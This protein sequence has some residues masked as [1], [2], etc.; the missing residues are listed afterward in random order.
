MRR[1][2]LTLIEVMV[3][4]TIFTIVIVAVYGAFYMGVRTWQRSH[5]GACLQKV[6]LCFLRMEKEL[7]KSLFFSRS[8]FKGTPSGIEFPVVISDEE[9]EKI[10]VITYSIDE[11]GKC[12]TRKEKPFPEEIGQVAEERDLTPLMEEIR[13][14][15]AYKS[16]DPSE[17]LEWQGAWDGNVLERLPSGV[18]ISLKRDDSEDF[19]KKV[20][21]L[22]NK[23]LE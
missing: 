18:R 22:Q 16:A 19:Y 21:F 12:I 20:I 14:E 2:G 23:G 1:I 11:D 3:A 15:Y 5:Q 4:V 9:E 7:K 10:Y 6:R 17:N 8:A 13:F